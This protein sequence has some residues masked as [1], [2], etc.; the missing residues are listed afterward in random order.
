MSFCIII[1]IIT[2]IAIIIVIIIIIIIIIILYNYVKL[3]YVEEEKLCYID[4][5][6]FIVYKKQ[7]IFVMTLQK[8]LKQGS[9]LE[10]VN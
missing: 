5:D 9:I 4:T 1:I 10:I 8:M 6:S 3:K 2:I 7:M